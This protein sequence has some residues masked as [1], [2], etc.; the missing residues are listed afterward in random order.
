MII[1][2][3]LLNEK[4]SYHINVSAKFGPSTML[5][6]RLRMISW[7]CVFC[8]QLKMEIHPGQELGV[9]SGVSISSLKTKISLPFGTVVD[10]NLPF[11]KVGY[12]D[13]FPGRVPLP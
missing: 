1:Y 4:C 7:R 2:I 12:G 3:T 13:S 11:S 5:D 10:G 9:E 8:F 6:A